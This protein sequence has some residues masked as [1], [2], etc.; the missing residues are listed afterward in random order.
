MLNFLSFLVLLYVSGHFKQKI[1]F[2]IFQTDRKI[3]SPINVVYSILKLF[4]WWLIFGWWLKADKK[5]SESWRLKSRLSVC[6]TT[7]P[8]FSRDRCTFLF[9]YL[10]REP[11]PPPL[12]EGPELNP[13]ATAA[14]DDG[15]GGTSASAAA[16]LNME[17]T[18]CWRMS[19]SLPLILLLIVVRAAKHS[20]C[21]TIIA[22][23]LNFI[24]SSVLLGILKPSHPSPWADTLRW[25]QQKLFAVFGLHSFSSPIAENNFV[26]GC[27]IDSF[28]LFSL[29]SLGTVDKFFI[30]LASFEVELSEMRTDNSQLSV[31]VE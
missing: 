30:I 6:A 31:A 20:S 2:K 17:R 22:L 3:S 15:S 14:A 13:N 29:L 4:P 19:A 21:K 18:T 1:F 9:G 12:S 24:S 5:L 10:S 11:V 23:L 28:T 26:E 7:G 16:T 25:W 8:P 27:W